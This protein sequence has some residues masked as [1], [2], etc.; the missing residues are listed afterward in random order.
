[1]FRG[2]LL[3]S[4]MRK[5]GFWPAALLSS[6]LFAL[7]HVYEVSTLLGAVTLALSVGILGLGNCYVVRVTGRLAP[8][9]LIHATYN[10]LALALAVF[11]AVS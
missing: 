7:F 8:A 11:A 9:I 10:A 4:F 6:L 1:M 3:R 2:L 5:L